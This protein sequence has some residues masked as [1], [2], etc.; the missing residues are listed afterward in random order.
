MSISSRTSRGIVNK[1]AVSSE[2]HKG[3]VIFFSFAVTLELYDFRPPERQEAKRSPLV[4]LRFITG[5]EISKF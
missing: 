2:A 3:I 4:Q 1:T 5:A